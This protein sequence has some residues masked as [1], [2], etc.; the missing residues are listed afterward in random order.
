MSA[1]DGWQ[2]ISTLGSSTTN[3][4]SILPDNLHILLVNCRI[5]KN[6][7]K[8]L[9]W[10]TVKLERLI[11]NYNKLVFLF[12]HN[13]NLPECNDHKIAKIQEVNKCCRCNCTILPHHTKAALKDLQDWDW[14]QLSNLLW[15]RYSDHN[16][17]WNHHTCET[18]K[19]CTH[20]TISKHACQNYLNPVKY[21]WNVGIWL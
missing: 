2:F 8:L 4:C 12:A 9:W 21:Q 15:H 3:T 6:N 10:W 5:R 18:E 20:N 17:N 14:H 13:S 16:G 11:R 19:V 1:K 7:W